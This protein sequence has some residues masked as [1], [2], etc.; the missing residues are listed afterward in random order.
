MNDTELKPCPFCG[1]MPRLMY[2]EEDGST[3]CVDGYEDEIEFQSPAFVHCY[4]CDM[5]YFPDS[6]NPIEVAKAWNRRANDE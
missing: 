3:S 5:D 4:G 6:D 2:V 1:K